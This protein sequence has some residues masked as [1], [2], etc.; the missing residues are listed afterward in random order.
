MGFFPPLTLY[1]KESQSSAMETVLSTE[2]AVC[3]RACFDC[4]PPIPSNWKHFCEGI[5]FCA[6]RHLKGEA[7]T[8]VTHHSLRQLTVWN[9]QRLI[10]GSPFG[11]SHQGGLE[12]AGGG[13]RTQKRGSTIKVSFFVGFGRR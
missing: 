9:R 10:M 3:D 11:M 13:D 6:R 7:P 1:T 8:Q 5:P 2:M 4:R 12:E